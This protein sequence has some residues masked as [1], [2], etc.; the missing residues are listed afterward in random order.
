MPTIEGYTCDGGPYDG[1]SIAIESG[2]TFKCA[3]FP[4]SVT[5]ETLMSEHIRSI[6]D[7]DNSSD[8]PHFE[9]VEY[10]S[11]KLRGSSRLFTVLAPEGTTE[12]DVLETL[13]NSYSGATK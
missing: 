4:E 9:T 3:V 7:L 12:D 10:H 11:V 8:K 2:S 6:H 5:S 13:I 1:K